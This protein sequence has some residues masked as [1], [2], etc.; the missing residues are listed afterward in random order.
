MDPSKIPTAEHTLEEAIESLHQQSVKWLNQVSFWKEESRFFNDFISNMLSPSVNIKDMMVITEKQ[1]KPE[2]FDL[3]HK[4]ISVHEKVLEFIILTNKNKDDHDYRASHKQL[5]T[6]FNS[7]E[8]KINALK[9]SIFELVKISKSG[10]SNENETLQT[11][12]ERRA[13]RKFKEDPVKQSDLQQ[14][15]NAARMA[16]SAMNKQ[17]W[18][19]YILTNKEKIKSYAKETLNVANKKYHLLFLFKLLNDDPVFHGAP[20]V[21]FITSPKKNEWAPIDIGLCAQNL[22]LA[23]KSLGYDTC[24]VGFG[25]F[26]EDTPVYNELGIPEAEKIQL[27]IVLGYGDEKPEAHIRRTDNVIYLT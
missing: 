15:I 2:E 3:L 12:N 25:R 6:R 5:S 4:D 22:M 14:M 8:E 7:M 26:I 24:P 27:A 19:F 16:P 23:A 21:I 18:K 9:K 1:I 17:P 11:I 10:F 13:V 20:V